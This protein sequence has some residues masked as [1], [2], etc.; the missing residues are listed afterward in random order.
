[1]VSDEPLVRVS[2]CVNFGGSIKVD[3]SPNLPTNV[4]TIT[5][6]TFNCS[7][8]RF[9]H[10]D[11]DNRFCSLDYLEHSLVIDLHYCQKGDSI[12]HLWVLWIFIVLVI[13]TVVVMLVYYIVKKLEIMSLTKPKLS[14]VSTK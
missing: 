14:K 5:L 8:G 10:V 2:G 1:M 4:S 7:I 3:V 11:I 12:P 13:L 9:D 6:M